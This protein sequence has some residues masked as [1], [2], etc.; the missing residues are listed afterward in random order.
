MEEVWRA[1]LHTYKPYGLNI[2]GESNF[3]RWV[4]PKINDSENNGTEMREESKTG[5][6]DK[7]VCRKWNIN[8][9]VVNLTRL[10]P[11]KFMKNCEIVLNR[12]EVMKFKSS[13]KIFDKNLTALRRTSR[14]KKKNK[15]LDEKIWSLD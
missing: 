6:S 7:V 3:R 9:C 13:S 5:F 8:E 11:S 14:I 10:S 4:L 1:R 2:K 15:R 12:E